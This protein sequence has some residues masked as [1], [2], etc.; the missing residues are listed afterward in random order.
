MACNE[1]LA[2]PAAAPPAMKREVQSMTHEVG[3]SALKIAIT[4]TATAATIVFAWVWSRFTKLKESHPDV[5]GDEYD[6]THT[7]TRIVRAQEAR[8]TAA[9]Q[10]LRT[11]RESSKAKQRPS[12]DDKVDARRS[13]M[14]L[15]K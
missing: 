2:H 4:G 13:L 8:A 11:A 12:C 9:E 7:Y 15:A 3:I 1:S 6:I 5:E 14:P 10:R